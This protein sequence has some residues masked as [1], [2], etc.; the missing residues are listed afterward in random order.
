M[1]EGRRTHLQRNLTSF[2][3]SCCLMVIPLLAMT[4]GLIESGAWTSAQEAILGNYIDP[5]LGHKTNPWTNV[6][7]VF[8]GTLL[9]Y[10]ITTFTAIALGSIPRM[11]QVWRELA[12]VAL[13]LL[14]SI[15]YC[16]AMI[17]G[18]LTYTAFG[19]YL[20]GGIFPPNSAAATYLV[21][22][23]VFAFNT[24]LVLSARS[25][26]SNNRSLLK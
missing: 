15:A 6:L 11:R 5:F 2:L 18:A 16:V 21:S 13:L 22:L 23:G 20:I 4:H 3:I 25:S 8:G 7:P 14:G 12:I 10:A 26:T 9:T 19:D 17:S 24:A 1:L